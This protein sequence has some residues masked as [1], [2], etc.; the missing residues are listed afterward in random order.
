MPRCPWPGTRSLGGGNSVS[1]KREP[2]E[3]EPEG[4]GARLAETHWQ[5]PGSL[6]RACP[7]CTLTL[8]E[9]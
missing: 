8:A 1:G 9:T 2:E 3:L 5:G 4:A 7:H 6:S